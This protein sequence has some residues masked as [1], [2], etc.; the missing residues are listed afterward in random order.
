MKINKKKLTTELRDYL[1]ITI[2]MV[3]YLFY[4]QRHSPFD[5]VEDLRMALLCQDHL[6]RSLAHDADG[7]RPEQF[8][9]SSPSR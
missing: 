5:S 7:V 3:C 4:Y 1:M 6:C 9:W 8:G 2:A